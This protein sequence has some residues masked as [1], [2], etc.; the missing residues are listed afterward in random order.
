[1]KQLEKQV[2]KNIIYWEAVDGTQFDSKEECIEYEK[3]TKCVIR[4]K[5]NT[6]AKQVLASETVALGM[7]DGTAYIIKFENSTDMDTVAQYIAYQN[8]T[9][10]D[11]TMAML[12]TA[13]KE[14]KHIL[15]L[16]DCNNDCI[17]IECILEDHIEKLKSIITNG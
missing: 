3:T 16:S 2:Q 12:Q 9:I 8:N 4:A 6:L 1:M 13:L 14:N 7:Y 15:V 11:S 17:W 5:F 10:T